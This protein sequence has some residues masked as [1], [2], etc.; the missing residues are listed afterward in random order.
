MRH[1]G[2]DSPVAAFKRLARKEAPD[3]QCDFCSVPLGP[4][5]RH[6]IEVATRQILCTCDACGLRFEGVVA[7]R[8]KLIPRRARAL[9]DFQINDVQWA[10]LGLPIDLSFISYSSP[11]QKV[12]AF[13]PS[14]GGVIESLLP[15]NS[16]DQLVADNPPLQKIE[17]DSEAFLANRTGG[18]R[19]YYVAPIDSCFE[20]AGLVRMHW[21]GLA[22]G[23][24][25]W[26]EVTNFFAKLRSTATGSRSACGSEVTHA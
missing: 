10:S 16:W 13:Y 4:V 3:E 15:L 6:L 5:H 19:E 11:R 1:P 12:L 14:P 18:A 2:G 25:V 24:A 26:S 9:P 17:P 21:R 23:T 7:G 8:Y 20:L 22:G